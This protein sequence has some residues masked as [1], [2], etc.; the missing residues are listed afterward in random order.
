MTTVFDA[1]YQWQP[2]ETAP[3]LER[4]HICGWVAKW[5]SVQAYWFY[6]EGYV[7][8]GKAYAASGESLYGDRKLYWAPIILPPF[9]QEPVA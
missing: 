8:D 9:P 5:K 3:E 1:N 6:H 4:I 2:I 7:S